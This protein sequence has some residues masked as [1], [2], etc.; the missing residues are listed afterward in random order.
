MNLLRAFG[1]RLFLTPDTNE[2]RIQ[3]AMRMAKLPYVRTLEAS[4]CTAQPSLDA[5]QI[6]ELSA[7]QWV[8]NGDA[9][10]L[11]D[12][13]GVGQNP[14]CG[15]LCAPCHPSRLF[16]LIY[17]SDEFVSAADEST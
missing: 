16:Y 8:A 14:S 2:K 12:P 1:I 13:P 9:L 11:L 5:K 7:C 4:D 3:M 10:L 6:K 17:N 15:R